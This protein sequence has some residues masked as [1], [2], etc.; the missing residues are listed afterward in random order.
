MFESYSV[1]VTMGL[2]GK[3]AVSS[4]KIIVEPLNANSRYTYSTDIAVEIGD[5][6]SL[7]RGEKEAFVGM[8]VALGSDYKGPC[9]KILRK[10]PK[11]EISFNKDS[12]WKAAQFKLIKTCT[13]ELCQLDFSSHHGAWQAYETIHAIQYYSTWRVDS[14]KLKIMEK[15]KKQILSSWFEK[16]EDVYSD[17]SSAKYEDAQS[18]WEEMERA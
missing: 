12:F 9:K 4:K 13:D 10:L 3:P 6:V 11:L 14:D 16:I 17:I 1:T 7:P 2:V 15:T 8:V 5:L 18:R